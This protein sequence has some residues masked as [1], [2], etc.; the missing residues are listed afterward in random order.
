MLRT[1]QEMS[2]PEFHRRYCAVKTADQFELLCGTVRRKPRNSFEHGRVMMN[3][4][5]LLLQYELASLPYVTGVTN[6]SL[7]LGADS[8]AQVDCALVRN[9]EFGGRIRVVDGFVTRGP[10][11]VIE[12]ADEASSVDLEDRAGDLHRAGTAEYLVI[13]LTS[14]TLYDFRFYNKPEP[15]LIWKN[16]LWKSD[17]FPGLRLN[18]TAILAENSKRA[19][20]SVL[21]G[22]RDRKR[23][24]WLRQLKTEYA[25]EK[26]CNQ[27]LNEMVT[28]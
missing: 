4:T 3:L 17:V 26:N 21:F 13:C 5:G 11:L 7:I 2:Q 22:L 28:K 1:G 27:A 20:R 15:N 8:E 9:P 24:N 25:T 18:F 12:V 14:R 6:T 16:Q 19:L 10:E 23:K